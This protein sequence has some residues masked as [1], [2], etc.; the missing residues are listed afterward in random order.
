MLNYYKISLDF[1]K[2]TG[3]DRLDLINRL[4]S[5]KVDNLGKSKGTKTVLTSDKGRFIDLLSL[6]NFG[7]FVFTSC[8]Y[9][10]LKPVVS[11][12]D[13]YTIM[14]DFKITDMADT[15]ETFL[16][17]GNDADKFAE[18]LFN[19]DINGLSNCDFTIHSEDGKD[20][21]IARNDDAFGGF[22][23]I[24]NTAD[25][26]YYNQKISDESIKEKFNL[27]KITESE[28]EYERIKLGIPKFGNEM[29]DETNPLECGLAKYVSFTKGCYIG[30]EVIARLDTYDKI[31]K[32]LVKLDIAEELPVEFKP[33][34][35]KIIT[36]NKEC[37]FVTSYMGSK[38]KGNAGLG[39]V[40]TPFLDFSKSYKIRLNENETDC[41][42]EKIN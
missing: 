10:N 34:N 19:A 21:M 28:F 27:N 41:R 5:N 38:N 15:H 6:Y 22:L 26:E 16:F 7:D 9:K 32:H 11:H 1:L 23:F 30:Q 8:S 2:F 36:D 17:Y 3:N 39:F 29:T 24:Y 18:E 13:K 4:S 31:S 42:L 20:T 14:D 33:Y 37:G 25:S 35:A 12:L 40:K